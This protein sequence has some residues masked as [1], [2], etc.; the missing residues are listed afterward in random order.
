M[1]LPAT[2]RAA[3][4]CELKRLYVRPAARGMGLG[5]ALA[6]SAIGR[7][8]I[9][10]VAGVLAS[11][12]TLRPLPAAGACSL[13]ESDTVNL[14]AATPCHSA[15]ARS[16]AAQK[17]GLSAIGTVAFCPG[18]HWMFSA[19]ACSSHSQEPTLRQYVIVADHG[20]VKTPSSST[21]KLSWRYLPR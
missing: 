18:Y 10:F 6:A 3:R 12:V 5:R 7:A 2:A 17:S 21:V 1:R 4:A 8:A 13:E 15:A 16:S 19:Q 20:V 11:L 9:T 14:M